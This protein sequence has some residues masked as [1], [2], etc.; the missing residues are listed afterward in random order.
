MSDLQISLLVAGA[1][2]IAGVYLFNIWQER[3]FRRRSEHAF[4]R[5][6][7]DVLLQGAA[8]QEKAAGARVEPKLQVTASTATIAPRIPVKSPPVIAIDPV[9]DYVVEVLIP[10]AD[11]GAELHAQLLALAAGWGKPVL[12]AGYAAASGEWHAAGIGGGARSSQL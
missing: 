5:E 1:L 7:E 4:A 3:Q 6:H 8:A 12:V 9:I 10:D 2:V 11:D